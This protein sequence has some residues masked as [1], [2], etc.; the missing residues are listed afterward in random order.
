M[1]NSKDGERASHYHPLK[2]PTFLS[3][4]VIHLWCLQKEQIL[5]P[6]PPQPPLFTTVSYEGL[7]LLETD[8]RHPNFYHHPPLLRKNF[9][10]DF[11]KNNLV[12]NSYRFCLFSKHRKRLIVLFVTGI[13]ILGKTYLQIKLRIYKITTV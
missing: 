12:T 13:Y 10:K 8:C 2:K 7:S 4:G 11:P 6:P 1:D 5:C 3:L 9:F